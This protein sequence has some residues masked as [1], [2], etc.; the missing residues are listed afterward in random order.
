MKI[1]KPNLDPLPYI[2]TSLDLSA[3]LLSLGIEF[4]GSERL[5][6]GRMA[7]HFP[8]GSQDYADSYFRGELVPAIRFWSEIKR[9]KSLVHAG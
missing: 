4:L 6:D 1:K 9:L 5:P 7:F 8:H 2:T 3:F